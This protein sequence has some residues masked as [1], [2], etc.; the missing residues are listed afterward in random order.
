MGIALAVFLGVIALAFAAGA[1]LAWLGGVLFDTGDIAEAIL[2]LTPL[3]LGIWVLLSLNY[4][5]TL[6]N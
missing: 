3:L 2:F 4:N 1:G 5:H 6:G